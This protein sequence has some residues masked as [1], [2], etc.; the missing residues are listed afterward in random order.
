M[1]QKTNPKG[2][3]L[4]LREDWDSKWYAN[5]REFGQYIVEDFAIRK[6]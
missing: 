1:G 5:K 3:R 2:L 4:K 6:F